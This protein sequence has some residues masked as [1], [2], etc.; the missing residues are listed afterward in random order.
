MGRRHQLAPATPAVAVE[1]RDALA[2]VV[3]PLVVKD[4]HPIAECWW[5]GLHHG[6]CNLMRAK[7]DHSRVAGQLT[8]D[9]RPGQLLSMDLRKL[10]A[11]LRLVNVASD[12][13]QGQCSVVG[14][15]AG[16]Y[17]GNLQH[18]RPDG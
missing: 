1:A 5:P 10:V 3:T 13:E 6:A 16:R 4:S 8:A 9:E 17:F 2:P 18:R 12:L 11:D 14:L 7:P 15:W